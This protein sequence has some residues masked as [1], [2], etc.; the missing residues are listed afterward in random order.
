MKRCSIG[1]ACQFKAPNLQHFPPG[2]HC[3]GIIE[4][5]RRGLM[6]GRADFRLTKDRAKPSVPL[7][8][9]YP[10]IV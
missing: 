10:Y 5:V 9:R 3:D 6:G 7:V 4:L 1:P 8:G 2:H